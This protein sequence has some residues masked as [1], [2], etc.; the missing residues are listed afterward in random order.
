MIVILRYS[1]IGT[2]MMLIFMMDED[3]V[4]EWRM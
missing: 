1:S 3:G 4:V 2:R